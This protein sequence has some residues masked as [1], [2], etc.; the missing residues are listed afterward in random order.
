MYA[1][2]F[3]DWLTIR[4]PQQSTGALVPITQSEEQ[5]LDLAGYQDVVLWGQVVELSLGGASS[6]SLNFQTAATKDESMFVTMATGQVNGVGG[7]GAG[8][9]SV[10]K[11]TALQPLARWVRWQLVPASF[12]STGTWDMT[13]RLLLC[14]NAPG[15]GMRR[16]AGALAARLA[17]PLMP[18]STPLHLQPGGGGCGLAARSGLPSAALSNVRGT[19]N[20]NIRG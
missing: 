2:V 12:P 7:T 15:A 17:A 14:A 16:P 20:P 4:G 8:I 19:F 11:N 6:I 18:P 1:F 5:W 3:Q 13:F 9:L 10:L